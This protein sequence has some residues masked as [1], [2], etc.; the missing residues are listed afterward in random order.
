MTKEEAEAELI[1]QQTEWDRDH[2]PSSVVGITEFKGNL[3]V[4]TKN[5]VYILD[6]GKF[7]PIRFLHTNA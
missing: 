5:F 7:V 4:A 3:Y 1:R 2:P 6:G